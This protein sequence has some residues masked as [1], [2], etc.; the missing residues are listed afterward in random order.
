MKTFAILWHKLKLYSGGV[1]AKHIFFDMHIEFD[2]W[3]LKN[4]WL[5]VKIHEILLWFSYIFYVATLNAW[6][7]RSENVWVV[8]VELHE[9]WNYEFPLRITC[10]NLCQEAM[11]KQAIKWFSLLL[12]LVSFNELLWILWA[13]VGPYSKMVITTLMDATTHSTYGKHFFKRIPSAL[14][15]LFLYSYRKKWF[16]TWDHHLWNAISIN[17]VVYFPASHSGTEFA[18]TQTKVWREYNNNAR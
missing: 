10:N 18:R 15:N 6:N 13:V 8:Q 5:I 2:G 12:L 16:F 4:H 3:N 1:S 17:I 14:F 7:K 11:N 9:K